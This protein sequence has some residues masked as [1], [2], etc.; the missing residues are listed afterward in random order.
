MGWV[1]LGVDTH[2]RGEDSEENGR[3]DEASKQVS[4]GREDAV[5]LMQDPFVRASRATLSRPRPA[6][7][8]DAGP[9]RLG[10]GTALNE[11]ASRITSL[12]ARIRQC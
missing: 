11:R 8:D 12:E 10:I 6:V 2:S 9:H 4:Q 7:K 1:G 5:H 3:R